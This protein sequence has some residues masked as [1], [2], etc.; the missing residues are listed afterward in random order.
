MLS[1]QKILV[2]VAIL[3][4]VWTIFKFFDRRKKNLKDIRQKDYILCMG[5]PS[6][7]AISSAIASDTTQGKIN[8]LKWDRQE[9]RYYP[10]EIDL[11]GTGETND[12]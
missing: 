11:Y 12:D 6:I 9:K 3:W 10:I 8:M 5:D 1:I 7:I 2:L 4:I